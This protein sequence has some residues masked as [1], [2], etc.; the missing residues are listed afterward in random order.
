M[1]SRSADLGQALRGSRLRIGLTQR[2]LAEQAGVSLRTVRHIEQGHVVRPRR[3]SIRR[4]ADVLE[5]HGE[6]A[7]TAPD[8]GIRIG[9]LGPLEVHRGNRV[10]PL[11]S[12]KQRSLF[13]L[14]ALQ[15]NEVISREEIVDV[16]WADR[17]PNSCLS[18]VYSF[19]SALR[20]IIEPN[21]AGGSAPVIS[22][23]GGGYQL[24][25]EPALV[26]CSRFDEQVALAQGASRA[27]AGRELFEQ[28]LD[29]WRGEVLADL[30]LTVQQHPVAVA[31]AGRRVAAALAYADAVPTVDG[32]ENA[33]DRLRLVA[34]HDPLHEGLHARLMVTL[35]AAGQRAAALRVFTDIWRRLGEELGIQ[36]GEELLSAYRTV[37]GGKPAAPARP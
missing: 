16:L 37:T 12:L 29:L 32:A 7:L 8:S 28:A 27:D 9:V 1:E 21:C 5:R 18:M 23:V 13:A 31:L 36:P 14:L 24:Q 20:K 25:V 10:L 11:G 2:K 26:D 22:R 4:L 34:H 30:P 3:N 33:I 19:A 15:P 35:A 6:S 17:P